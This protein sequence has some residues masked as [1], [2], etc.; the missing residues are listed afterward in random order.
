MD[1]NNKAI[2]LTKNGIRNENKL[3]ELLKCGPEKLLRMLYE[4]Y[5]RDTQMEKI[6]QRIEKNVFLPRAH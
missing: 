4:D 3:A 2:K 1:E 6:S 5:W